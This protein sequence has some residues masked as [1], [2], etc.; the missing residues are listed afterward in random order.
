MGKQESAK[1]FKLLLNC[2]CHYLRIPK[3]PKPLSNRFS[4]NE[5]SEASQEIFLKLL[6]DSS[7][8]IPFSSE[9]PKR[10]EN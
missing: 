6:G 2:H 10:G 5:Q 4:M 1:S 7:A 3:N 8:E 9:I